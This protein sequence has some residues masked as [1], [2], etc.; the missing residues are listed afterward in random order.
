MKTR[1]KL[2]SVSKS[3]WYETILD[4]FI[5]NINL[6]FMVLNPLYKNIGLLYDLNK[7]KNIPNDQILKNTR[8]TNCPASG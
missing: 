6:I 5:T 3:G 4:S 1:I 8:F 2:Y 7:L